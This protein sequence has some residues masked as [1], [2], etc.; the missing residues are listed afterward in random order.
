[1]SCSP[2]DTVDSRT[3]AMEALSRMNR[4][5]S[6][7]LMVTVGNRLAGM[8]RLKDM[9]KFLDLKVDLLRFEL[10]RLSPFLPII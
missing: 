7:R 3:D 9:L 10:S 6:S 5:G 1:M 8:I 2:E 4:T